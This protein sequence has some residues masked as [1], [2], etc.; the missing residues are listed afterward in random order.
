M[1]AKIIYLI[2]LLCL[3]L[4]FY[5]C[6][7]AYAGVSS[8]PQCY[9][10]E[11]FDNRINYNIVIRYGTPYYYDGYLRYYFYEGIYYYPVYYNNYWYFRT[12]RQPF[13]YGYCPDNRHWRPRPYMRGIYGN[14]DRF[15]RV[16]RRNSYNNYNRRPVRSYNQNRIPNIPRS[17]QNRSFG[18]IS[19]SRSSVNVP[20]Q[21]RPSG[22]MVRGGTFG[23]GNRSG[24]SGVR[25]FGGR[26]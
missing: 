4:T 22:A 13:R 21:S 3:S 2:S 5:S 11:V 18:S 20:R 24:N 19:Q 26:R 14:P 7:T 25:S 12:F 10:Q 23:N 16:Y 17:T 1:K 6:D 9:D 15:G 8:N